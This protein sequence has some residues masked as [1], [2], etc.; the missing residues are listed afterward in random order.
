MDL[1]D[2]FSPGAGGR[3]APSS[4]DAVIALGLVAAAIA[5]IGVT[6]LAAIAVVAGV[7]RRWHR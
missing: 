1:I 5:A 3:I 4:M 2:L 6:M 7:V